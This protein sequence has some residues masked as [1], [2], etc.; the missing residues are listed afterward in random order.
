MTTRRDTNRRV[1][2][3]LAALLAL[4]TVSSAAGWALSTQGRNVVYNAS[5]T[6]TSSAY[7][8]A[9]AF[10]TSSDIC[11]RINAALDA[12]TVP[13]TV[14]DARGITTS[15]TCTGTNTPWADTYTINVAATVLL[16]PATIVIN[17]GWILPSGTRI[18]G[19]G[20]ESGSS[21]AVTTI[22]ASSSFAS[23]FMISMGSSSTTICP[24]NVCTGISVENL[25]LDGQS[26]SISGVVNNYSQ[27][28]SYV[29]H[30]AFYQING[31][32]LSVNVSSPGTPVNSGPY[33]DLTCSFSTTAPAGSTLCALIATASTRGIHGMTCTNSTAT[34][35]TTAISVSGNNDSIEDIQVQ[36]F[37]NG[38]AIGLRSATSGILVKNVTG[39]TGM[40]SPVIISNL[41]TPSD[42]AIL[43]VNANGATN[44]IQDQYTSTTLT[45]ATDPIVATYMLGKSETVNSSPS[46]TGYSRFTTSASVPTWVQGTVAP[47]GTCKIG[48]LYS[49]TTAASGTDAL[50]VCVPSASTTK[51]S[52]VK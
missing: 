38:V 35:P 18:I 10:S 23:T 47:S 22:Q 49:Y 17:T 42:I 13:G 46:V 44:T 32:G 27:E 24:S 36:G 2:S 39:S 48:S 1:S 6:T 3:T 11:T 20:A 28:S 25:R 16:P 50:Y 7:L 34:L 19:E 15:L 33:S 52:G 4:V 30:V 43:G 9:S 40:T 29:K 21:S 8:D 26:K 51:W 45:S 37:Q 41:F 12:V 5:G 14:V 31:T